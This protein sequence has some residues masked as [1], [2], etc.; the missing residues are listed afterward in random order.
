MEKIMSW[1][2]YYIIFPGFIFASIAGLL[3]VWLD[4]KVSARVQWREGPPWYQ[5][6]A[7]IGKL[8][9]KEVIVP[10]EAFGS[11]FIAAPLFGLAAV[12]LAVTILCVSFFGISEGFIG[13]IIVVWYLFAI[14][15]IALVYI[16]STSGNPLS[17][18]G[19]SREIKL[20]LSYDLPM[21]IV[22]VMIALKAGSFSISGIMEWQR[23]NGSNIS[24]WYG[25]IAFVVAI[26][27][28]QAKLGRVPFDLPEAET[29]LGSGI[30]LELSGGV[31]AAY[32][33]SKAIML[34]GLPM[35]LIILFWGKGIIGGILM[36]L[37]IVVLLILIKNTNPRV[38]ID[39]AMK[40][41]WGWMSGAAVLAAIL[42]HLGA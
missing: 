24:N 4:R 21:A 12:T 22:I 32:E 41:F 11:G 33:L 39:H 2:I 30:L 14:P 37:L 7:D 42:A 38:R 6:F 19:V 31:L 36:Y 26:F 35:F 1:L 23:L 18:V 3:T 17:S 27:C 15:A 8:L 10:E 20:L 28:I 34:F 29:E 13:D 16:G 25:I 5:G 9:Y 40:Y